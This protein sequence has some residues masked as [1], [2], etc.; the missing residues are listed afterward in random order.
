[1]LLQAIPVL[2]FFS[3]QAEVFYVYIDEEKPDEKSKEKKE[4]KEVLSLSIDFT[5]S[6][7]NKRIFNP[8]PES[9]YG[10]PLLEFLTPPPDAC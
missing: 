6:L 5:V 4:G 1:M 9:V 10:S 2:H 3:S 7:S 8:S